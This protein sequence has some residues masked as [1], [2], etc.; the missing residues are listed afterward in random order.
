MLG[1]IALDNEPCS[2]VVN[3][4]ASNVF[5]STGVI[6]GDDSD[7]VEIEPRGGKVC[8]SGSVAGGGLGGTEVGGGKKSL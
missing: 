7:S 5:E 2:G 3:I 6:R 8:K 4:E 1:A